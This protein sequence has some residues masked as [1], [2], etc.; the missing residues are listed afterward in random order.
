MSD[1]HKPE[2]QNIDQRLARMES[3]IVRIMLH[4]GLNPHEISHRKDDR[5]K[6]TTP[7]TQSKSCG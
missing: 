6:P 2:A 4:L 5:C 1:H 3:R 7:S